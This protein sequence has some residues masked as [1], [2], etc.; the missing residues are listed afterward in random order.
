VVFVFPGS[1]DDWE[2]HWMDL[3]VP[4]FATLDF[5]KRVVGLPG[6]T[7]E[8]RDNT[9]Y[10]NGVAQARTEKEDYS[11]V[12]DRCHDY[13]TKLFTENLGSVA[14]ASLVSTDYGFKMADY[15]PVKVPDGNIFAM[16]DNRDHSNDSRIW[17]FVPLRNIKGKARFVWMSYDQ[18]QGNIPFVGSFRPGRAF[19]KIQ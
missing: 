19:T 10:V 16:G 11:F 18:C 6:D 2:K 12:D 4:P 1:D 15:G 9:V 14:H 7:I 5:V 3:P 17:G 13:P 8:V